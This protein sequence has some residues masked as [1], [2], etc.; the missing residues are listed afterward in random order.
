V[1]DDD[2]EPIPLD[3]AN[4]PIGESDEGDRAERSPV[5]VRDRFLLALAA[6]VAVA[7]IL[8]GVQLRSIASDTRRNADCSQGLVAAVTSNGF[9]TSTEQRQVFE[10]RVSDCLGTTVTLPGNVGQ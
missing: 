1:A 4:P 8:L 2:L 10:Q 6:V 5:A 7:L 3:P 9:R